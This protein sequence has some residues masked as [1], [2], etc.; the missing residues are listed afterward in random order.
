MVSDAGLVGAT[1]QLV[2]SSRAAPPPVPANFRIEEAPLPQL[3]PGGLLLRVLYLSL[4]PYMRGRMDD[5]KSYAKP[6]GVGEVM[7]GERVVDQNVQFSEF[8]DCLVREP[9]DVAIYGIVRGDPIRLDPETGEVFLRLFQIG[10]V[11]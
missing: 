9:L 6:L 7:S 4:D 3:P 2:R 1:M 11:A 5:A 10:G 8:G